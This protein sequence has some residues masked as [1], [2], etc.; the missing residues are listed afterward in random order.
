M[1]LSYEYVETSAV[2]S[3]NN[4]FDLLRKSAVSICVNDIQD[5]EI[6]V[7]EAAHKYYIRS[8][9]SYRAHHDT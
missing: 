2:I 1:I 8:E 7:D 6:G 3:Y 5:T 9:F 4:V